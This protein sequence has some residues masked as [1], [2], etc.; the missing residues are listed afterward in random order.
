MHIDVLEELIGG[1]AI[2]K[3][4]IGITGHQHNVFVDVKAG[5]DG[6]LS[7]T[8]VTIKKDESVEDLE[9]C[10]RDVWKEPLCSAVTLFLLVDQFNTDVGLSE[11]QVVVEAVTDGARDHLEL[12]SGQARQNSFLRRAHSREDCSLNIL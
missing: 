3:L 7:I 2:K 12:C 10:N 4:V 8:V 5:K 1:K 6:H 9:L 11:H